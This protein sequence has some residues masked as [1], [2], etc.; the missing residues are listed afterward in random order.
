MYVGAT[1]PWQ[2]SGIKGRKDTLLCCRLEGCTPAW[3][4]QTRAPETRDWGT[5]YKDEPWKK[6]KV[7]CSIRSLE[8]GW[9]LGQH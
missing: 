8:L 7:C 4:G 6:R 3:R 9:Q 2:V 5:V 1:E